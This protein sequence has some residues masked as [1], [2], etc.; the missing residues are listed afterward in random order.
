[1]GLKEEIKEKLLIKVEAPLF[2]EKD[3]AINTLTL[4]VKILTEELEATR[5][6]IATAEGNAEELEQRI[7]NLRDLLQEI[8]KS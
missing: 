8:K 3:E 7:E 6:R 2:G 4:E 1:L 5:K